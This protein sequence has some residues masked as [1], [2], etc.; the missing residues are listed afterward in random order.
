MDDNKMK[1]DELVKAI[2]PRIQYA[3][4][5]KGLSLK[6]VAKKTG[7]TKSYLSQIENMKREPPV[8]TLSKIAYVL[9]VDLTFLIN[10]GMQNLEVPNLTIVRKGEGKAYYGP[11]GEKG[12]LYESVSYKKPDRLMDGYIIT[13][14]PE[15]PPEPFLHEG[16]ELVYVLE[17]TQEFIYE[18]KTYLLEQGDCFFFDS[19][20]PHYSR[21]LGDKPGKILMVFAVQKASA[22]GVL[23]SVNK[24]GDLKE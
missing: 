5:Q 18:G 2:G 19:N 16:Q 13:I 11:H 8:S 3:R 21:T 6:D 4:K 7:F 1:T 14:G 9:E 10:G 24:K 20:R 17:G 12:Y 23:L 15:F 22:P